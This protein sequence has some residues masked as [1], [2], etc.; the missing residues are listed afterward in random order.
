MEARKRYTGEVTR[1]LGEEL[2]S[3]GVTLT[4]APCAGDTLVHLSEEVL[5]TLRRHFGPHFEHGRHCVWSGVAI[6]FAVP[7]A[8]GD[9]PPAGRSRFFAEV[10]EVRVSSSLGWRESGWLLCSA[11]MEA[12]AAYL[13][14]YEASQKGGQPPGVRGAERP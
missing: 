6:Y 10:V 13:L 3:A 14:E 12:A 9:M 2:H 11:A 5:Q 1:R 8:A 4:A 7:N